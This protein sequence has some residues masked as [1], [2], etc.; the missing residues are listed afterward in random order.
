M[1]ISAVFFVLTLIILQVSDLNYIQIFVLIFL[2]I[3]GIGYSRF[4][5][6][7]IQ[8]GIDQLTDASTD[9]IISFV[10]W[11]AWAYVTSGVVSIFVSSCISP[12]YSLIPPLLLCVYASVVICFI[13]LCNHVL[14]STSD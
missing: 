5:A 13:F 7:I 6:N 4:Q 14:Q 1:W 10:N 11:Y 2:S 9:E 12:L 8:F 3:L